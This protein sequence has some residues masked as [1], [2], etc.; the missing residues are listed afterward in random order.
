MYLEPSGFIGAAMAVQGIRDATVVLHGQNGCRKGLLASQ[1]LLVRTEERDGRFYGKEGA[2][3]YSNIRPEDYYRGTLEKL[4]DVMGHLS[5]EGYGLRV[6]MCSP[7][8][9]LVGDD[10]RKVGSSDSMIL[11][12]D[13]LPEDCPSG[14]DSCIRGIVE[15]LTPE[16][17]ERIPN[18]V[19]IIGLSIMHKD[20]AS[21]CHELSHLLKDAGFMIV[22][23][24]GAGCSTE[25]IRA[26]A[27][28]SYNIVVDPAYA[29]ETS[30]LYESRFGIPSI[31]IGECPIGYDATE[32][33]FRRIHEVTGVLPDHGMGMLRKSKRRAYEGIVASGKT[34]RGR[35]F[36]IIS[37][38]TTRA[39]LKRWLE[40]SFGMVECDERPDYLFAPG[41]IASLEQ[42]SGG[43]RRGVDI[44]FPS[45]SGSDFL[46][47]PLMG[48]E[49]CMY[50]LDALF[51][52]RGDRTPPRAASS[53]GCGPCGCPCPSGSRT[54]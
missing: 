21:Y 22:C 15:H 51:N 40:S 30:E 35:T 31:S 39:P 33:L 27:N 19:N 9:S 45:S 34:M 41:N 44:G 42:A 14:F 50:I 18:G 17:G 36:S 49:G 38:E 23:V 26:S 12:T 3:P 37:G 20:W 46:K 6:V 5:S 48:L 54:S 8:I 53:P 4:E 47:K 24:L 52:R 13:D 25:D 10:L 32:S 28:A 7:G 11:D 1:S 2:I 43:C 16:Q 29:G